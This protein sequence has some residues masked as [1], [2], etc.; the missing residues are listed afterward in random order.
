MAIFEYQSSRHPARLGSIA[1]LSLASPS[2][3]ALDGV[4]RG[5]P[6]RVRARAFGLSEVSIDPSQY[7]G[8]LLIQVN[9]GNLLVSSA[10]LNNAL[11]VLGKGQEE[12]E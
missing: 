9:E 12:R 4:G 6:R 7:A 3:S 1:P 8:S 2:K 5:Q 11:A 10:Q